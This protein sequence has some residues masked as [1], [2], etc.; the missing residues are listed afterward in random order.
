M[1][2]IRYSIAP[3]ILEKVPGYIRGLVVLRGAD[4]TAPNPNTQTALRDVE[5]RVASE[6]TVESLLAD[7]RIAA[8]REAFKL[9]GMSPSEFRPAH[10]SLGRRAVQ[11]KPLPFINTLVDIGNAMS[12]EKLIPVGVHPIENVVGQLTVRRAT[13]L[14][15]F[16]PFGS[17]K[18]ENPKPGEVVFADELNVHARAWVW[19]QAQC[20]VTLTTSKTIIVNIDGLSPVREENIEEIGREIEAQITRACGGTATRHLLTNRNPSVL[21]SLD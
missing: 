18:T 14:E 12:L 1:K 6:H 11:G 5:K 4:N 8:W 10:E 15:R 17:N 13:G 21:I 20:S 16:T 2:T 7:P 9:F 3:A 19:R